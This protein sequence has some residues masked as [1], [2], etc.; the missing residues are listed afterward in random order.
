MNMREY[1]EALQENGLDVVP[2]NV[3]TDNILALYQ[4]IDDLEAQVKELEA[5]IKAGMDERA[6]VD[7]DRF[8]AVM[9][10]A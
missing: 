8:L 1:L 4:R 5:F 7:V 10:T 6:S 3:R 2:E 9:A